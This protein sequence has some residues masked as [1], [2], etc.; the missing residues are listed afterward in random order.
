VLSSSAGIR[1][2]ILRLRRYLRR[3]NPQHLPALARQRERGTGRR[4]RGARTMGRA[5]A[6]PQRRRARAGRSKERR[7]RGHR[8]EPVRTV[9]RRARWRATLCQVEGGMPHPGLRAWTPHRAQ[10]PPMLPLHPSW[11][12]SP[13]DHP[14]ALSRVENAAHRPPPQ[15]PLGAGPRLSRPGDEPQRLD[16]YPSRPGAG[17]TGA[18]PARPRRAR[19]NR[20]NITQQHERFP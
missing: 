2:W 7:W 17:R 14:C 16:R 3:H 9:T 10:A 5:L 13:H 6:S 20:M 1:T 15:A 18:T 12:C 11:T 4:R 19:R 8:A